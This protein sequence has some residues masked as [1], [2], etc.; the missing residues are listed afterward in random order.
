[1]DSFL[2]IHADGTV[3]LYT[4]KVDIGTGL[5]IA[6]RQIELERQRLGR[7]LHTGVGQM[8]A[9]IRHLLLEEHVVAEP[10][11]AAATA[12]LMQSVERGKNAVA[13]VTGSNIAPEVLRHRILL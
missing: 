11:G 5:R 3:T 8:L 1:V 10:A 13:L 7:E 12:A 2:A 9:A 6:V 4:G